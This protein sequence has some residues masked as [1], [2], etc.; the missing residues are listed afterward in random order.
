[1]AEIIPTAKAQRWDPAEIVRALL[2]EEAAGH[3]AAN[4]RT[5]RTRAAFPTG[6]TFHI[7]NEEASLIP[8][9]TQSALRTLEWDDAVTLIHDTARGS[10]RAV[11]NPAV[12]AL[13]S[14]YA[15][16]KPIVDETSARAA[17]A[18]VTVE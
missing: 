15:Y 6:K 4:L 18:E 16:G 1:M 2:A 12:Q 3:D 14:A 7:W 5:R 8:V 17:A 9:P 11:N 13:L 10:P